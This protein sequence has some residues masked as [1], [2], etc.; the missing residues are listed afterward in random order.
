MNKKELIELI[1]EVARPAKFN[2]RGNSWVKKDDVLVKIINLQKSQHG[3]LYYINYDFIIKGFDL[4]G[5]VSHVGGRLN[6]GQLLDFEES[7][8]T[9]D[10]VKIKLKKILSE[11]LYNLESVNS[12]KELG[13][14]LKTWQTTS[15][16]PYRVKARLGLE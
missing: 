8:H 6:T 13:N 1:N 15:S 5:F 11:L 9:N 2:R 14:M 10:E 4:D 16:I 3:N 7:A 12:E